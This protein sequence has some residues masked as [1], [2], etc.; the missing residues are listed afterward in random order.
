MLG[1]VGVGLARPL[2]L[3]ALQDVGDGALLLPDREVHERRGATEER[4]PADV[5]GRGTVET[6]GAVVR[7]SSGRLE[8]WWRYRLARVHVGVDATWHHDVLTDVEDLRC[9]ERAVVAQTSDHLALDA[10][11]QR[12]HT[13]WGDHPSASSY[14]VQHFPILLPCA[15]STT[16]CCRFQTWRSR[17]SNS[18]LNQSPRTLAET[19]TAAMAMPGKTHIHQSVSM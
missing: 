3:V 1:V 8:V 12:D 18:S 14:G 4:G 11:V 17:G 9:L 6:A 2:L 16:T 7:G 15:P 13:I 5:R 19:M 10:D